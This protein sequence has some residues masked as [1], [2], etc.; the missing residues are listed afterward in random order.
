MGIP[1]DPLRTDETRRDSRAVHGLGDPAHCGP[2]SGAAPLGPDLAAVHALPGCW[3]TRRRLLPRGHRATEA[4]VLVFIEH[5]TRRMHL[6]GVTASPTGEWTVQ[7]ARNLALTLGEGLGDIRFLIRDRGSNFTASFDAV[8]QAAG[9][10][11]LRTAVQT[12]RMNAICERLAGTLRRELLDRVLILGAQHLH[13]VLAEYQA[14]YNTARPHQGIAQHV[15][16]DERDG[17][18]AAV[19]D[20]DT[21]HVRRKPILNGLINEYTHAA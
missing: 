10:R 13:A 1:P 20:I 5:G 15:P 18:R 6:G 8:F 19:T 16:D 11:I 3:D 21:Q 9:T 7:Q 2:R 14:H 4:P 12:P 17:I